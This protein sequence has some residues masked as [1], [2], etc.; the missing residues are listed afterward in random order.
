MRIVKI[1][2]EVDKSYQ[3]VKDLQSV[4][5]LNSDLGKKVYELELSKRNEEIVNKKYDQIME[6]IRLIQSENLKLSEE[7]MEKEREIINTHFF[8]QEKNQLMQR[9]IDELNAKILPTINGNKIEEILTKIKE[10]SSSKTELEKE[11]KE[12]R[13][14]NFNIQVRNDYI[15]NEKIHIEELEKKLRR[16]YSDEAS[17]TI[18]D[19]TKKL[20]EYKMAELK[21]KRECNLLKEKEEYYLRVNNAHT[22]NIKDIEVELANWEKKYNER[23]EF[24][25]KRLAEQMKLMEDLQKESAKSR[26]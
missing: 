5:D 26:E 23:E 11:N 22:E 9:N 25:R 6:E 10:I 3:L 16:T 17:I 24:W 7:A 1:E 8:M 21:A 19:L 15:E 4:S 12:L 13:E 18:I 14:L 20:S 2:S